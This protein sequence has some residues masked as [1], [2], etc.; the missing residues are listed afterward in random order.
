MFPPEVTED[1]EV[2]IR[3]L[4]ASL[5]RAGGNLVDVLPEVCTLGNNLYR[6]QFPLVVPVYAQAWRPAEKYIREYA[7]AAGW[8]P[9]S[10]KFTRGYVSFFLSKSASRPSR[11]R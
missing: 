8:S 10:I 9:Q 2:L 6:V 7:K 1:V 4:R 5:Q 3:N 11:K